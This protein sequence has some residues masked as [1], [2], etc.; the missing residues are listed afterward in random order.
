MNNN[1]NH[2][3]LI[4]SIISL[5]VMILGIIIPFVFKPL[6]IDLTNGTTN[7][8]S[9][10]YITTVTTPPTTTVQDTTSTVMQTT[11]TTAPITTTPPN[12]TAQNST[13]TTTQTPQNNIENQ[14]T[15]IKTRDYSNI[16]Y[17]KLIFFC[18][19]FLILV[20]FAIWYNK[21]YS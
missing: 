11:T 13:T 12:T 1:D 17:P 14:T 7:T 6:G 4:I 19:L 15:P 10:S 3:M 20:I 16:D 8:T 5:I 21:N 18:I 9:E 2:K